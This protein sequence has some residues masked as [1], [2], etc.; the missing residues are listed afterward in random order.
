MNNG[1]ETY[2]QQGIKTLAEE[3]DFHEPTAA[4]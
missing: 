2:R 3:V 4:V 1:N